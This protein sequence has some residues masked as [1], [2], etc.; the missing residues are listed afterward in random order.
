M[1]CAYPSKHRTP[2]DKVTMMFNKMPCDYAMVLMWDDGKVENAEFGAD[3][4]DGGEVFGKEYFSWRGEW[5]RWKKTVL[6]T[7]PTNRNYELWAKWKHHHFMVH[8]QDI[9]WK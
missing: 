6:P 4:L 2:P 5:A 1:G 9:I 7:I 3:T 8:P